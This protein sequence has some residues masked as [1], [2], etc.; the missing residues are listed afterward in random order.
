MH[1]CVCMWGSVGNIEGKRNGRLCVYLF[2]SSV[3]NWRS[4][5]LCEVQVRRIDLFIIF[6]KPLAP[7]GLM[8]S[9]LRNKLEMDL[10]G[11]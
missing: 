1:G 11:I 4:M 9:I 8:L 6:L 7:D 2:S 10:K 5:Y 3:L